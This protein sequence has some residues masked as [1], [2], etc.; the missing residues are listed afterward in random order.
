MTTRALIK[1]S[2][3]D[4]DVA[5][6]SL[7]DSA[8]AAEETVGGRRVR[9]VV[10]PLLK[11]RGDGTRLQSLRVAV[12]GLGSSPQL[13]PSD[14]VVRTASGSVLPSEVLDGPAGS[15]RVLVPAV[16][17]AQLV[18]LKLPA[19]D[20]ARAIRVEVNPQRQ[21]TIHL[22]HHSHL[23]IG[24]TDPQGTVL[25]EHVA[26][27][28]ACL[29]LTAATDSWPEN[30]RFRWAVESLWSFDQWRRVRPARRVDQFVSRVREGRIELTAMPYNLHTDTC[31][32]DE[33]HE[34]LRLA[35]DMRSDY[36][37]EFTTAM[38][39]DV[40]GTVAGLP[41]A[42]AQL[43]V[44]YLSVAHNYA[45]R[46]VPHLTGGANLPRLFRWRSPAGN[47]VLVWMTD[48][49]HGLAYMEGPMLGFNT[50]YQEVDDLLPSYLASLAAN[51]YPYPDHIFGWSL[52]GAGGERDPYPWDVLHLRVQG[53]F[54]DNAPP[55]LIMAETVRRWNET[56]AYPR[57]RMSRNEDFFRDAEQRL[58]DQITTFEGD[59]GD[60]WVEGVG[61]GAR[62]QALTRHAQ[63]TITDAQTMSNLAR[64]VGG[65]RVPH[66]A[67]RSR[68]VYGAV[69]LFNEHT[70]GA[71][72][73][74]T[75]GDQGMQS[76]D[77]QWHW[78]YG[79]ALRAIDAANE[80][81]DDATARLGAALAASPDALATYYAVNTAGF[82]RSGTAALF[83]R[84]SRVPLDVPVAV[85]DA[86]TGKPVP[87]E[88]TEQVN[89][90]HR[91]AG[92]F[93]RAHVE[94]VPA[95]GLVRLDVVPEL[96]Q[97]AA[98][99]SPGNGDPMV[100]ENAHLRVRID[101]ARACIASIVGKDTDRELVNQDSTVGFNGYV[102]D[103]YVMAGGFNHSSGMVTVSNMLE[104]LGGRSLARPAVLIERVSTAVEERLVYE[105][106]VDG[107][108][109]LRVTVRLPCDSTVLHIE[110]RLSKP[111]TTT[112]ESAF[113]AFP[114]AVPEP[115][116]R[117]EITGAV[118]GTGLEHVPGA[119]QHMRAV[120]SWV[121]F[122]GQGSP[123]AWATR[124]APLVHPEVIAL[125]YAPFP[126]STAPREP[127][128]VYS[129]VHNNVWDTNF[130]AQQGFEMSFHYA[131]GVPKPGA[132]E[133]VPALAMRTA[134]EVTNPL[135]WVV[136]A[137]AADPD[138]PTVRSLL[139][140]DDDRIRV[141][142]ITGVDDRPDQA[143]VRLQSF[144]E[145]PVR[146]RIGP[147]FDVESASLATY[148][149][150]PLGDA[151]SV[152]GAIEVP[153][154]RLGSV[155]VLLHIAGR[156]GGEQP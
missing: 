74:W 14:V 92:R 113:F 107:A 91:S 4:F 36:G 38:Q 52:A 56:W 49:P 26:F 50:S 45:G 96:D 111:A 39:T 90:N 115:T 118:T 123:V 31:S 35:R 73:P 22:V 137:G 44:R 87:L 119:P 82:A 29:D 117:Y 128:T 144:A 81:L 86:R 88:I 136:A 141:V 97:A 7:F 154:P 103:S 84:E 63:A 61:S 129:W 58:G 126:E 138:G 42:L 145:E 70:W 57:L 40:P 15:V 62:P 120:R 95:C 13:R 101:L 94:D 89:P 17:R 5:R 127:A 98:R 79:S 21:W 146:V 24:Y 139:E 148:L 32:T 23:D 93:L 48:S 25:A 41:D 147:Q 9:V 71:A 27:L 19:L 150:E 47:E 121:T 46:S 1:N 134:A 156:G 143:L 102:Y 3:R 112:K 108:R 43:G 151:A 78:K 142:S 60:W 125:P 135:R 106:P 30:A 153:V 80:F 2:L 54:A 6:A 105:S 124:D 155:A 28:D 65:E 34:L 64:L 130:P 67:D 72:E 77:Q 33:L 152:D 109:W 76:G 114:F 68:A 55:R 149:A 12:D 16:E 140:V 51:P 100:L 132:K 20:P 8:L 133:S 75:D 18:D 11:D 59:W 66:E 110:N 37:V 69:S 83:L 53:H 116:V 10:E 104:L 99:S 85:R 122:D 131:V